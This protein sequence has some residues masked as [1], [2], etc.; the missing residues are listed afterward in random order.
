MKKKKAVL[1]GIIVLTGALFINLVV[2]DNSGQTDLTLSN[3]EALAQKE[4]GDIIPNPQC[5]ESG[6]ICFGIDKNNMMGQHPGL[7]YVPPK[8]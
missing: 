4:S 5:I 8:K 6:T 1:I 3:I 2:S 7:K